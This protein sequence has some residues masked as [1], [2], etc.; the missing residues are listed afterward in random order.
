MMRAKNTKDV[1]VCHYSMNEADK[2]SFNPDTTKV[3]N[4]TLSTFEQIAQN[5]Q[6]AIVVF[7]WPNFSAEVSLVIDFC[8]SNSLP[9]LIVTSLS[10]ISDF[11]RLPSIKGA[12]IQPV[13]MNE[14]MEPWLEY[15]CV[16][17]NEFNTIEQKLHQMEQDAKD[18]VWIDRAKGLLMDKHGL[19]EQKAHKM[20]QSTAMNA[21]QPM[22]QIAKRVVEELG[23]VE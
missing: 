12:V 23:G 14:D 8:H 22:Y 7:Y 6:G 21:N 15:A 17:R 16:S 4:C 11:N 3:H 5:Q 13:T 1:I 19:T 18:R 9:L 2:L 20:I 10:K